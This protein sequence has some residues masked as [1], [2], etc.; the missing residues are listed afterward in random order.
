MR[1]L[2]E[3]FV[4]FRQDVTTASGSR[5]SRWRRLAQ[6]ALVI[7]F[8]TVS[9]LL[10][11][12]DAIAG[13]QETLS[14]AIGQ[15]VAQD[16]RAP[17]S[18]SFESEVLTAQRRQLAADSVRAVYDP[19]D[20]AIARRQIQRAREILDYIADVRAD[21]YA[22]SAM[23]R[24]DL[25]AI[26]AILLPD[27]TITAILATSP[28]RWEE[29]D[30]QVISVLERSMRTEIRED[31][32]RGTRQ[33]I[34]N[35]VSVTFRE[36]EVA[37]ITVLVQ[38]LIEVNTFFNEERTRQA[39]QAAAD[40]VQPEV[41]GF[42]QGQIV[43][44][45]GSIGS[46][47]DIEALLHFGLLQADD[48]RFPQLLGAALA[49]SLVLLMFAVYV[50]QFHP[51]VAQDIVLLGMLGLIFVVM[52]VGLRLTGPERVVQPYVFPGAA[53]GLIFAAL[54]GPQVAIMGVFSLAVLVGMM[55]S[56]SFALATLTLSGGIAGAL[57]LRNSERLNSY[58]MAGLLVSLINVIVVIIFYLGGYPS[59]SLGALTLSVAGIL[60]G[61]LTG[62]VSL[63]I[64][65]M[66][67]GFL[68]LPTSLRLLELTQPNQKLLQRLLREAP[69]TYQHS[70]Q[71]ANLA[72]LAAE[73]I[74]AN[75]LLTRVGALYHDVGKIK[76]P[77]FFIENQADGV[78]PHDGLN[79]PFKSAR[80]IIDHVEEGDRLARQF[81]LPGRVREFIREHHGTTKPQYFYQKALDQ[82]GGDE[83]AVDAALFAY[84]GP[85]P[86]SR[87]TAILMLADSCESSVRARSPRNKQ[88]IADAVDYIFEIRLRE[89]ELDDCDLSLSDLSAIQR[90]FVESLQ[91]VFHPRIL[92]APHADSAAAERRHSRIGE[93]E[94]QTPAAVPDSTAVEIPQ[95]SPSGVTRT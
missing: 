29:I 35:L 91:G 1:A 46:A 17:F 92:Y 51:R 42:E 18:T 75:G 22:G 33:N 28:D 20:P 79:D 62:V 12:F 9:T 74:G 89:G 67:S 50:G 52:L 32:L 14:L 23:L 27:E 7:L 82:A 25:S 38:G 37:L 93:G 3:N 56:N 90:V 68:N 57:V 70:L 2:R 66:L 94:G 10:V 76:A 69:G 24:A 61:I 39:Q 88:E 72:E 4:R 40:A 85:R 77:H 34:P 6:A 43:V 54:A 63:A 73:R 87:E 8:I 83:A 11:G 19:P 36:D 41:R 65:Y 53:L 47:A 45:A 16:V 55:V 64:L 49:S 78:N 58:F 15:V 13:G 26:S 59:D 31:T 71:V 80:I 44:R 84:P 21:E 30:E 86:Q 81:R 95:Q 60:N 5:G 48:R